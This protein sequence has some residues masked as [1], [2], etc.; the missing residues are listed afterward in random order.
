[1]SDI[2]FVCPRLILFALDST[3]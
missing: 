2:N 3:H 1:V